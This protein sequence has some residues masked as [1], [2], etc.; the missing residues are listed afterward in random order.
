MK[1]LPENSELILVL[2]SG[3]TPEAELPV[4]QRLGTAALQRC[5]EEIRL[6]NLDPRK[7]LV[8]SLRGKEG[9][10][11]QSSVYADFANEQV[12]NPL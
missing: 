12:V 1:L 8:F 2:G 6:W 3:G 5:I 4:S 9:Y 11:S 7:T 10:P